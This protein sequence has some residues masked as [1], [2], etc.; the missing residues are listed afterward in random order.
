MVGYHKH[1]EGSQ[2]PA[3]FLPPSNN[4]HVGL[5]CES[6]LTVGVCGCLSHLMAAGIGS[7]HRDPK[8][9]EAGMKYD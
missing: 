5:T 1:Q 8:E 7:S 3:Y 4:M 6:K 2:F 9:D